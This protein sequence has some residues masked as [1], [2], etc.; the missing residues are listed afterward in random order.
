MTSPWFTS[1]MTRRHVVH[2]HDDFRSFL[3][4][5]IDY[6]AKALGRFLDAIYS[7]MVDLYPASSTDQ[8]IHVYVSRNSMPRYREGYPHET[9]LR[10]LTGHGSEAMHEEVHIALERAGVPNDIVGSDLINGSRHHMLMHI[11]GLLHKVQSAYIAKEGLLKA[12]FWFEGIHL[13]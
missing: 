6:R 9:Y 1:V 8:L 12:L 10:R 7:I 3:E 2:V 11:D 4:P 13:R 5:W